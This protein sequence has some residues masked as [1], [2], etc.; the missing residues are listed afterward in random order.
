MVHLTVIKNLDV[1]SLY[2][3][4]EGCKFGFD[5]L[6]CA[7]ISKV[8]RIEIKRKELLS[9]AMLAKSRSKKLK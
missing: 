2:A 5:L 7:R 4:L 1:V 6:N 9:Y 8:A 3:T